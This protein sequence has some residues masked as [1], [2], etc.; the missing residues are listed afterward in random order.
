M[1]PFSYLLSRSWNCDAIK[2]NDNTM[3]DAMNCETEEEIMWL[4]S[5]ECH[6]HEDEDEKESQKTSTT[7]TDDSLTGQI[8]LLVPLLFHFQL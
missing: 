6:E 4:G 2:E 7:V 1:E 3:H 8:D 5:D